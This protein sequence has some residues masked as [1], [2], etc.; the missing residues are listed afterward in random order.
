MI[1]DL[2]K[3]KYTARILG[4]QQFTGIHQKVDQWII[5]VPGA[6]Y[7][8]TSGISYI[9][10]VTYQNNLVFLNEEDLLAFRLTFAGFV[11]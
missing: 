6:H 2:W 1:E 5:N 10:G 4:G 11:V 7:D 9:N 8:K 3:I